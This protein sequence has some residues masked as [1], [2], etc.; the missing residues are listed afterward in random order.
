MTCAA[1]ARTAKS[2]SFN[3]VSATVGGV[4]G[5]EVREPAE[6]RRKHALVL[7]AEHRLHAPEGDLGRQ[8]REHGRER[9]TNAPLGI[10]VHARQHEGKAFGIDRRGGAECGGAHRRPGIGEQV[11]HQRQAVGGLQRAEGRDD[12]ETDVWIN[13][14]FRSEFDERRRCRRIAQAPEGPDRRHL[15]FEWSPGLLDERLQWRD[16]STGLDHSEAA[17]GECGCVLPRHGKQLQQ[18]RLGPRIL[19]AAERIGDR[20]PGRDRS[21]V[22][23]DR[24]SERLVGVQAHERVHAEAERL[25][26]RRRRP[27][28]IVR[29]R[30]A[31]GGRTSVFRAHA[32]DRFRRGAP[33]GFAAR[34]GADQPEGFGR[35]AAN[36]R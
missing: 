7:V 21:A 13:R 10:G 19:D 33:G 27:G 12:F 23:E 36:H 25:H 32:S 8:R 9:R 3:S 1:A 22:V 34:S 24:G 26:L 28:L 4:R 16:G 30:R 35:P 29:L 15:Y 20:P 18:D 17:S 6:H 11:L 14:G 5:L 2:G 31:N